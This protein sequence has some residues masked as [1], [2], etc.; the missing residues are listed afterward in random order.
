MKSGTAFVATLFAL[1]SFPLL[2]QQQPPPAS[3]MPPGSQATSP[4]APAIELSPGKGELV[5]KLDSKTAK[6]GDSIVVQTNSSVKTS[7]GT[8]IPKGS[9]VVG[10]VMGVHP[11]EEGKNSQVALQFD[12]VELK[13][14]QSV[15]VHS[16]IQSIAPAGGAASATSGPPIGSPSTPS[17]SGATGSNRLN[18]IPQSTGGNSGAP[19]A[20]APGTIVAKNGNIAISATSIPG[21]LLANNAPG[22]R[23]PRRLRLRAFCSARRRISNWRRA[24][25][26]YLELRQA[27]ERN[28]RLAAD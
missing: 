19:A 13:G 8:E 18:G 5:S 20:P 26:W 23:D 14:G 28:N 24:Q 25:R 1:A 27:A 6:A 21:V 4:E 9:K 16:E 22:L 2:A 17:T 3:Q 7:D 12:H 11:S 10:H 15:P